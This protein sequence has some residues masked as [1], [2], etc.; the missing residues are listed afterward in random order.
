MEWQV[1]FM[2]Y[3]FDSLGL[4]GWNSDVFWYAYLYVRPRATFFPRA[5]ELQI[6][7]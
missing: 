6:F 2:V 4:R 7:I 5:T 3:D 1:D